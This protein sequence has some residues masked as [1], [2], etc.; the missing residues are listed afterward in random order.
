MLRALETAGLAGTW[1][2][3]WGQHQETPELDRPEPH[4]FVGCTGYS[5][6]ILKAV[7]STGGLSG[8]R[9]LHLEITNT[10][11]EWHTFECHSTKSARHG[12][13]VKG[14]LSAGALPPL[15]SGKLS[16]GL[17][18]GRKLW[19][20]SPIWTVEFARHSFI[21]SFSLIHWLNAITKYPIRSS[22]I[23]D[24]LRFVGLSRN[25]KFSRKI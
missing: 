16:L 18:E 21:H 24:S 23:L 11:L 5:K 10:I 6:S 22:N 14:H 3:W 13:H 15:G 7:R 20:S 25:I 17:R 12:V 2:H 4:S 1:K 8:P 19:F 9:G